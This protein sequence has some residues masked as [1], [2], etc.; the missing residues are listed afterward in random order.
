MSHLPLCIVNRYYVL[1]SYQHPTFPLSDV[2]VCFI[3]GKMLIDP[4]EETGNV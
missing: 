3:V 2:G 4:E 1:V